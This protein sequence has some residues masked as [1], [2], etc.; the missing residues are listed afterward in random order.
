M[1]EFKTES[2]FADGAREADFEIAL[3]RESNLDTNSC[4]LSDT[5]DGAVRASICK[6]AAG[7]FIKGAEDDPR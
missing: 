6:A 1:D 7:N 5:N 2:R 3:A 4:K